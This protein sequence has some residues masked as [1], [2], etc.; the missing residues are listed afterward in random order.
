MGSELF[1]PGRLNWTL[2]YKVF[3]LGCVD[4]A[5]TMSLKGGGGAPGFEKRLCAGPVAVRSRRKTPR[6]ETATRTV[7]VGAARSRMRLVMDPARIALPLSKSGEL[8]PKFWPPSTEWKRP[9]EVA[10][11]SESAAFETMWRMVLP[12]KIVAKMPPSATD[13]VR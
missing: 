11:T 2:A 3:A 9:S 4:W 7:V 1:A 8:L 13:Q 12:A 10:T 5:I 6:V